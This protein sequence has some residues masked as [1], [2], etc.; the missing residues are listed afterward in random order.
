MLL[1]AN[2]GL[3]NHLSRPWGRLELLI[4]WNRAGGLHRL[5]LR[6]AQTGLQN[7]VSLKLKKLI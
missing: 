2:E 7:I 6:S 1:K 4:N 3:S 5:S